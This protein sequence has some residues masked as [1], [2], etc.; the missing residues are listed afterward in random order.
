M[1]KIMWLVLLGAMPLM[2]ATTTAKPGNG[3]T[4]AGAVAANPP[5]HPVTAAQVYEILKLTGTDTMKREM[6]DGMLPHLKQM[7]PYIP[8]N[9]LEDLEQSLAVADFEGAMVRSFQQHLSTEDAADI[10]AFYRSPA[11]RHMITVMP[12]V[13]D[14]G[15]QAGSELGQQVML[16]VIQ[17]HRDEIDS[18]AKVYHEEHPGKASEMKPG[19]G[20]RQ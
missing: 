10:I 11:G 17:R 3:P 7:M 1:R 12:N 14:E 13:L 9:A 19:V 5:A 8:A 16:D 20:P 4:A 18:A 6:M 15:Q 2:A